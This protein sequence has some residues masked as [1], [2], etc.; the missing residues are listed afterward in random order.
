MA[1]GRELPP[2]DHPH[3]QILT[4]LVND[5]RSIR[6]LE[7]VGDLRNLHDYLA[8]MN[9]QPTPGDQNLNGYQILRACVEEGQTVLIQPFAPTGSATANPEAQMVQLQS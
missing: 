5:A 8:Q 1:D 4:S 2:P 6:V 9:V 7:I 3:H